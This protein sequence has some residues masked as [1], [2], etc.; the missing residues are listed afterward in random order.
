MAAR[1]KRRG[2][3]SLTVWAGS[4][5]GVRLRP[6]RAPASSPIWPRIAP[7]R[8]TAPNLSST[9]APSGPSE[10]H[11]PAFDEW[12]SGADERHSLHEDSRRITED[13]VLSIFCCTNEG[14][15]EGVLGGEG[16]G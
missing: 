8:S 14:A 3:S 2:K 7:P 1:S 13:L 12:F 5:S 9:A 6:M 16:G 11:R 4:R 15:F 10:G